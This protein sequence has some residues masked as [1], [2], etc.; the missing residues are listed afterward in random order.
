LAIVLIPD[1]INKIVP[2]VDTNESEGLV[3]FIINSNNAEVNNEP[4]EECA[5]NGTKKIV[6][7]DG[8][9]T[10]CTCE[11][12]TCVQ[13]KNNEQTSISEE[14]Y[15]LNEKYSITKWTA[16]WCGPCK[17]WDRNERPSLEKDGFLIEELD[18]DSNKD[19]ARKMGIKSIPTIWI[20][21]R[22][23]KEVKASLVYP[24]YKQIISNIEKLEN[25]NN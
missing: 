16:V 20:M 23:T 11:V 25:G 24:S 2:I 8:H 19:L 6:H 9:V 18:Y 17:T 21:D 5:C 3:A 4:K 15:T 13:K 7:G 12:C 10:P 22:K 14:S 1:K